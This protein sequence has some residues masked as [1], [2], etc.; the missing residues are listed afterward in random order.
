[1]QVQYCA[2]SRS[3][4]EHCSQ[5][6]SAA[7]SLSNITSQLQESTEQQQQQQLRRFQWFVAS[8]VD[9][10][11]DIPTAV[12]RLGVYLLTARY[13]LQN[14]VQGLLPADQWQMDV[15]HWHATTMAHLQGTFVDTATG[16]PSSVLLPWLV[17]PSNPVEEEMCR[18][19][20]CSFS[21]PYTAEQTSN[22][23]NPNRKSSAQPTPPSLSSP[24]S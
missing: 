4:V 7:D 2:S 11:L 13:R 23:K 9:R 24:S 6:G 12:S 5:L 8:T 19:Q 1:M 20:V 17:R 22:Q 14:G 3:G 18:S 16:P 15:M 21:L 10:A